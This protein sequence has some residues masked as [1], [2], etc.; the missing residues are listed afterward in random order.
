MKLYQVEARLVERA[1]PWPA[2]FIAPADLVYVDS[3]LGGRNQWR[4]STPELKKKVQEFT[5]KYGYGKMYLYF[6]PKG[7]KLTSTGRVGSNG[8]TSKEYTYVTTDTRNRTEDG[9]VSVTF[10]PADLARILG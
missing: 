4:V 3:S 5:S 6:I 1:A 8:R 10:T 9:P 7:A 2:S